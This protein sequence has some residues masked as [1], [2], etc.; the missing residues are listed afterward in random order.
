MWIIRTQFKSIERAHRIT[1]ATVNLHNGFLLF[2][3]HVSDECRRLLPICDPVECLI[4]YLLA[5]VSY[6]A[7]RAEDEELSLE[8]Q[9]Q[10]GLIS[11]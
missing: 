3:C 6:V 8:V 10:Y 5:E 9:R 4:Y 2:L 11:R 7:G 1:G